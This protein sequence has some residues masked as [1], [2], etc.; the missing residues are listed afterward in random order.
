MCET[1]TCETN[2]SYD[3]SVSV[4]APPLDTTTILNGTVTYLPPTCLDQQLSCGMTLHPHDY[5]QLPYPGECSDGRQTTNIQQQS[6]TNMTKGL[7]SGQGSLQ[8]ILMQSVNFASYTFNKYRTPSR[9]P[10]NEANSDSVK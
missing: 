1:L 2:G 9:I 6:N 5:F 10:V 7:S 3:V 8:L 4:G